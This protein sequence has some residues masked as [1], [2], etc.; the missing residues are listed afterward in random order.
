LSSYRYFKNYFLLDYF[1][2][3]FGLSQAHFQR[4]LSQSFILLLFSGIVQIALR[5]NEM[6]FLRVQRIH[7]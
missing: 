2:K 3:C 7:P 4:I 6:K 5:G 1:A